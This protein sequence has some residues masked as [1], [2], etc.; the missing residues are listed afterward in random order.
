MSPVA[1]HNVRANGCCVDDVASCAIA[2]PPR[3]YVSCTA[4]VQSHIAPSGG[5]SVPSSVSRL[6]G[7]SRDD[8]GAQGEA[9]LVL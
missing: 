2:V 1:R 8:T 9:Y 7:V 3:S 6:S 5:L 4:P